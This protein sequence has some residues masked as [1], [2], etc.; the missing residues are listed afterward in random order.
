MRVLQSPG[1]EPLFGPF[2]SDSYVRRT[3]KSS[4]GNVGD[5][6]E[7]VHHLRMIHS[8][9][10][11]LVDRFKI[12]LFQRALRADGDARCPRDYGN[13][14]GHQNGSVSFEHVFLRERTILFERIGLEFAVEFHVPDRNRRGYRFMVSSPNSTLC[15]E[16]WMLLRPVP[17]VKLA[18][19]RSLWFFGSF[20]RTRVHTSGVLL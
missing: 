10:F 3:G 9:F 5:V 1:C 12:E 4:A 8:L 2:L 7:R 15:L 16:D 18:A 17:A 6:A 20:A 13:Q 14:D 19:L 11:D